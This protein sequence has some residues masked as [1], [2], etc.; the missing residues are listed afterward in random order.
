N[1]SLL[2][3]RFLKLSDR[4]GLV[5]K[6]LLIIPQSNNIDDDDKDNTPSSDVP[7]NFKASRSFVQRVCSG[8]KA[9]DPLA[10]DSSK[11][12]VDELCNEELL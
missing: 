9:T 8:Q 6:N 10:E 4:Y 11:R 3:A 5:A 7:R 1:E 12:W 2:Y